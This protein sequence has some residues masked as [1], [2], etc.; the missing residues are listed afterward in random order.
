VS[1]AVRVG[2]GAPASAL[3]EVRFVLAFG[4]A[5]H[6]QVH[7]LGGKGSGLARL[8]AEG[9]PA[10]PGFIITTDACRS[11]T[12]QGAVPSGLLDEVLEHLG[13][14]ERHT[15]KS[16]GS[17]PVPLLLSVRSGAPVSMPGMMDTVLNLGLNRET[18]VAIA[19]ASGDRRFMADV[20]VRFHRMYA[21]IVLGASGDTIADAATGRMERALAG[22]DSGTVYD[23]LWATCQRAVLDEAGEE[24]PSDPRRQ[25]QG[26]IEAVFRSWNNR[27]AVTYR[28]FH[29]I[30][31]DLGTAVVVQS[32]VFGNL[33]SPSGSG[34]V[35]T[36]NPVTGDPQPYG[37]YLEGGQGEDVVAGTATPEPI[38][39]A[40]RRLPALF[41]ELRSQCV[42]LERMYADVLDIEF[43]VER[44]RLYLLQVRSA[45]RT[46][47]AAIRIAADFLREAPMPRGDA[48]AAVSAEQIRQLE[49]PQFAGGVVAA[50]TAA[51]RLLTAGV[52]AS[53]G[54][55][56]GTLVLDPDRAVQRAARGEEVILARP[57]TSPLDLHGMI[58][59]RGILT[60]TGG[61]TSHAAVVARALGKPCVT[62]CADAR[63]EP[64]RGRLA[65][66]DRVVEEGDAVSIDGLSGELFAGA[67][68]MTAPAASNPD[69]G[70]LLAEADRLAG[71]RILGRVTT[72]EHVATVLDRGAIGVVTSI[73]DVLATTGHLDELID[74]LLQQ[75]ELDTLDLS[76]VQ[77]VIAD[78]FEPLL[79]AAGDAEMGVRAIDFKADE[80]R[81]LMQ[82]TQ[83]LTHY[84]Q[85]SVP[86]GMPA[87]LQAQLAGL[88][89]AAA[90]S[91]HSGRVYLAVRHVSDPR[92][93]RALRELSRQA[94]DGRVGVGTYLTS[95]R[96]ALLS[97]GIAEMSDVVW[98]E[99]RVMQAAMFG[100]P[101]WQLLTQ[102]PLDD[103]VKR[104]LIDTDPRFAIDPTL[105]GILSAVAAAAADHPGCE[106]GMRLSGPV[107]EEI[108]S[109]LY[110]IGFRLFAVD[111][112][113]VRPARLAFGKAPAGA[114]SGY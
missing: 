41:E 23:E 25:L 35:F 97:G 52:G 75:R 27:R 45:K 66:G 7:L 74:A 64:D 9:F 24:V 82:Q 57:I 81:E 10:P 43:T 89:T 2:A 65:V 103:Y 3:Q 84:P 21:E 92:E 36:R 12:S 106:I 33:G 19:E 30:P 62:G 72:P 18:A 44:G 51:G 70:F 29:R 40:S 58:A 94:A 50:A 83:L 32:M 69:L 17:G 60:A 80:S 61:A 76:R 78:V 20:L 47:E 99:V 53:P 86:V 38:T 56:S 98:V 22:A 102:R 67:L 13:T 71:C 110:R 63:I 54:Q 26:A 68:P 101:P 95:P 15:G 14:L 109:T 113:E 34:V 11:V 49:R 28:D 42:R 48:L 79:R 39:S 91:G 55:V 59:A 16:F 96:G 114:A 73:D 46:P 4:E 100:I 107:S 108:A 88:A 37:E 8:T 105:H 5:D 6:R 93:A 31:H 111:A 85:L 104:G 112:D 77:A 1:E 90:R 87:L